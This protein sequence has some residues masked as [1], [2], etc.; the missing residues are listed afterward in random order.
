MSSICVFPEKLKYPVML[1]CG[2]PMS[3]TVLPCCLETVALL[4]ARGKWQGMIHTPNFVN[5]NFLLNSGKWSAEC[6]NQNDLISKKGYNSIK[7][8]IITSLTFKLKSKGKISLGQQNEE[9]L[10]NL[11]RR[12]ISKRTYVL[13]KNW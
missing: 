3:F 1:L 10:L 13:A 12:I 11:E 8:Q 4:D 6:F 7:I 9:T 5:T 2:P